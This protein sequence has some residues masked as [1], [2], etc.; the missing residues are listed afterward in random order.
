MNSKYGPLKRG[1]VHADGK[2]F[3][4][5]REGR[6]LWYDRE[7]Y[8]HTI[9]RLKEY[10]R[11]CRMVYAKKKRPKIGFYDLNTNL[12]CL[13]RNGAKER[14]VSIE[15]YEIWKKRRRRIQIKHEEN[16]K[17]KYGQDIRYTVGQRHP[18]NH[19]LYFCCYSHGKPLWRDLE[20]YKT[21]L[22]DARER[23]ARSARKGR[24]RKEM[25]LRKIKNK[26]KRGFVKDGLLFWDYDSYGKPIFISEQEFNLRIEK[27]AARVKRANDKRK[28][29]KKT[30]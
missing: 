14:W 27:N 13:G 3:F 1:D 18:E 11:K 9:N 23:T 21:Y 30:L 17:K 6:E 20:G 24:A 2:I 5:Y 7:M 10:E 8:D 26:L 15:E 4:S 16:N 29:K 25:I 19:D 22:K 12:Y 28:L